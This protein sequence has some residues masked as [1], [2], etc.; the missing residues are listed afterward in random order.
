MHPASKLAAIARATAGSL[1]LVT[2]HLDSPPHVLD[3]LGIAAGLAG[4]EQNCGDGSCGGKP[5]E[6]RGTL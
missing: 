1:E 5:S 6:E 2:L 4:A 3:T